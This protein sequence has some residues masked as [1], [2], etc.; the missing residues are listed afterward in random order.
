[1]FDIPFARAKDDNNYQYALALTTF[2]Q[3]FYDYSGLDGR[4]SVVVESANSNTNTKMSVILSTMIP[5][6]MTAFG[7]RYLIVESSFPYIR[8]EHINNYFASSSYI[9]SNSIMLSISTTG[10]TLTNT[11]KILDIISGFDFQDDLDPTK[12]ISVRAKCQYSSST[13]IQ[14]EIEGMHPKAF[15]IWYVGVEVVIYDQQKLS[16]DFY[17]ASFGYA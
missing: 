5:N 4:Y 15:K 14:C 11:E 9:G 1:V 16:D 8:V 12:Y 6:H 10:Y 2:A 17:G 3:Q 13:A 7:I